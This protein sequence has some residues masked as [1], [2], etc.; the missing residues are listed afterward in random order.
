[1][2]LMIPMKK[3]KQHYSTEHDY[4]DADWSWSCQ[5]KAYDFWCRTT[6]DL[7]EPRRLFT[8][9]N[10]FSQAPANHANEVCSNA[11]FEKVIAHQIFE[12]LNVGNAFVD[13]N[14]LAWKLIC[15]YGIIHRTWMFMC[16]TKLLF[17]VLEKFCMFLHKISV[18]KLIAC[19]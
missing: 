2:L 3:K 4:L 14:I 19:V 13:F 11:V 8:L 1:M 7:Q 6:S 17:D 9:R 15:L 5:D 10:S 12:L 18:W 16:L